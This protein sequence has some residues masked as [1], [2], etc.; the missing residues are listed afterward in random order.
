ML[1]L[2]HSP[3]FISRH[4]R[5]VVLVGRKSL[6][7]DG[8]PFERKNFFIAHAGHGKCGK[9]IAEKERALSFQGYGVI[10]FYFQS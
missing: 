10:D 7:A 3:F 2:S 5:R 9:L 6:L 1:A 4:H 8:E